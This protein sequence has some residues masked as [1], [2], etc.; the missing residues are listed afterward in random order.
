MNLNFT[1]RLSESEA[2]VEAVKKTLAA[3]ENNNKL[4]QVVPH[5]NE[6]IHSIEIEDYDGRISKGVTK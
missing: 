4:F 3:A 6:T 5:T 1:T 2:F